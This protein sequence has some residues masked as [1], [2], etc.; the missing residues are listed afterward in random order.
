MSSEEKAAWGASS[1]SL[2]TPAWVIDTERAVAEWNS[3]LTKDQVDRGHDAVMC[4]ACGGWRERTWGPPL[5]PDDCLSCSFSA[6]Q[7]GWR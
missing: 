3:R 7:E 5:E 1:E 6:G 4:P 2:E